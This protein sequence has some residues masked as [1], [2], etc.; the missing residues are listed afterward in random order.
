MIWHTRNERRVIRKAG[1]T[2]LVKY[3]YDG[4]LRGK[5]IEVREAR[6]DTRFRI[7]KN[8]HRALVRGEG[9]YIFKAGQKTKRISARR[10]SEL[11][12]RGRWYHDRKPAYSHKFLRKKQIF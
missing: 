8:T 11:L 6:K 9:S 3:G 12:G 7:Q 1:G 5:P 2:P 10:V 4:L